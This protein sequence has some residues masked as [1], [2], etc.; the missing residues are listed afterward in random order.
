MLAPDKD[1]SRYCLFV[2]SRGPFPCE[3]G[4]DLE[5]ELRRGYHYDL[6]RR[7][8]QLRPLRVVV[9]S[10]DA[11]RVYTDVLVARG[12]RLGDIKP[13]PLSRHQDWSGHFEAAS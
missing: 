8:G 5:L 2:E 3:I 7:L 9:V 4:A 11:Y 10:G 13:T 6:C 1:A 12:M